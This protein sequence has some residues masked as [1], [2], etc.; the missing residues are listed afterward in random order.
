MSINKQLIE[1]TRIGKRFTDCWRSDLMEHHAIHR[2]VLR[3]LQYL[4]Q[5]PRDGF[6]F[7]ILI[8]CEIERVSVLQC[9]TKFGN[10]VLLL[11]VHLVIGLE[12]VIGINAQVRPPLLLLALGKLFR[13]G[14]EI[15]DVAN[16][17]DN[18]RRS[19]TGV[20]AAEEFGDLLRLRGR[21]DDDEGTGHGGT[22]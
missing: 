1:F 16:R 17:C 20:L 13:F 14:N 12:V 4:Q 2:H 6:T 18:G 22:Q 7:A 11:V 3:R 8:G 21:L 19:A 9:T 10:R 5:M 15:S